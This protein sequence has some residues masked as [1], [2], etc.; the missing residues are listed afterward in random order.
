MK[1]TRSTKCSLKFANKSKLAKLN[2]IFDEYQTVVNA[3][4]DLFWDDCPSRYELKKP[5]LDKVTTWLTARLCQSAAREAIGMV[6]SSKNKK[7]NS[8]K[9]F[10]TGKVMQL[11][12]ACATFSEAKK[13]SE[14]DCWLHLSSIGNKIRF[15]LPVRLHRHYSKLAQRGKRLN[16][17]VLTR[18]HVQFSFEIETGPKRALDA[19]VGID[20]GIK[21][22][23][24]LSTGEQYGKDI[25]A[26]ITR[27]N[28]CQHGSKGQMRASCALRNRICEVAK[29]TAQG[30]SLVVVERFKGIT[31]NT[32][33]KRR[34]SKNMRRVVSR[35]NVGFWM[36]RLQMTC[37]DLNVSFRT[38][39]PQYTSQTCPSCGYTDKKNRNGEVFRCR[40]C[41]YA[42]NADIN[43][44]RNILQRFLTGKYGTGC[45]AKTTLSKV[46]VQATI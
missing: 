33:L 24:S 14:F 7:R 34:L 15:D 45:K 13:A 6:K 29:Q 19:C 36:R 28:R 42:D 1:I 8:G 4:I 30:A 32:K 21:A 27:V 11:S 12:S 2:D 35:W 46:I 22:L 10:H 26:C 39:S 18:S 31:L 16:S 20:T 9:P 38:V 40:D 25:E 5:I 41:S 37:E 23:A 17:Y 43:A 3:F 44:A